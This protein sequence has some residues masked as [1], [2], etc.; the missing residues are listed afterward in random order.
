MGTLTG[1]IQMNIPIMVFL[2]V[3]TIDIN[4][5][6]YVF[7]NLRR[8]ACSL[9]PSHVVLLNVPSVEPL[10]VIIEENARD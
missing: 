1:E 3:M 5:C 2:A 7:V 4:K 8:R 10:L 9:R 6:V